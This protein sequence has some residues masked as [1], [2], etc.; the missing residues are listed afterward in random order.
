MQAHPQSSPAARMQ[1]THSIFRPTS[2]SAA[3]QQQSASP[4]LSAGQTPPSD[5]P[6]ILPISTAPPE[7]LADAAG[8]AHDAGN[9]L[10]A[11]G[12]YC[13]LLGLPGVLR[14]EHAHY[15]A[16]LTLISNR[17][18]ELIRRLL[19][20]PPATPQPAPSAAEPV[21]SRSHPHPAEILRSITPILQSIA[22]GVANVSVSCA[23]S[24]AYI[25]F[26]PQITAEIIERIA[27]NLV[28]NATEAI[29]RQQI[30][31][32]ILPARNEIRIAFSVH[33]G[34]L[35][36]T[37][38]DTGPGMPP[39]MA[40]AFLHPTPLPPGAKRGLGHRIVHELVT[41]SGGSIAVRVR[42]GNGTL[43]T[44]KWPLQGLGTH[45]IIP[46]SDSLTS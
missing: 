30:T 20:L 45:P 27:I 2:N 5:A 41:T 40:A 23:P 35:Q 15:A 37:V 1:R 32:P 4:S 12:L 3:L 14:P 25:D 10:Q 6:T 42:P 46:A 34:R 31:S 43:F 18:A 11:L 33:N 17:S 21:P 24:L 13:E 26:P 22:S 19:A 28:R 29:R 9:L 36:L 44:M 39:A 38:E 8:L 7:S 16:E